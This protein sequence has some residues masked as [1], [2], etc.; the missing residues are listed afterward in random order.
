MYSSVNNNYEA[1][2]IG[3]REA[4]AVVKFIFYQSIIYT[5]VVAAKRAA[6]LNKYCK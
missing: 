4:A 1:V 2:R 3:T 5:I 6:G